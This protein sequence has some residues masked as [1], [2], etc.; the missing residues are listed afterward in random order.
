MKK[1][2]T[3]HFDF[4]EKIFLQP[5][6]IYT[7]VSTYLHITIMWIITPTKYIQSSMWDVYISNMWKCIQ[8]YYTITCEY[9]FII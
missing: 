4:L 1:W 9:L 8:V 6:F 5:I 3:W 7:F 2:N